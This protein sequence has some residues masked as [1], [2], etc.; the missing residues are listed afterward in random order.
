MKR[1]YRAQVSS[2]LATGVDFSL[3]ISAV[4]LANVNYVIAAGIGALAGALVNFG[5][6]RYWSFEVARHSAKQQG[7]RYGLVW[8]GSILLNIS[9]L[10]LLTDFLSINYILSK[11]LVAVIVG[12]GFNYTLQRS[13]VF[14]AR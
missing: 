3:T 9:G 2:L 8:T 12:L 10:Y 7:F 5:F 4:Q 13:Y 11:I 6:N 1:F 14:N